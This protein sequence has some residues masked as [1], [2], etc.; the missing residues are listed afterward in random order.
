MA[1]RRDPMEIAIES[2]LQ[3]GRFIAWNQDS[4]FV[5]GLEEVE[6]GIAALVNSDPVRAVR[7][8]EAFI[9]ACC[10]KANEIDSEGEFGHFIAELASGWIRAR[11]AGCA[12]PSETA[13]TLLSWIDRDNYGFLNDLGS[14]ACQGSG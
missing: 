6:R 8:H 12:D 1:R 4:A 10:L 5:T 2:A 7:L 11:R 13:R 14:D 3:A 9:A